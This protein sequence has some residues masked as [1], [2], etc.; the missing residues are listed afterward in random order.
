MKYKGKTVWITGAASGI[1]EALA[2]EYSKGGA[3]I[4]LSDIN[5]DKLKVVAAECESRGGKA[6][7]APF[8]LEDSKEIVEV[9]SEV[10]KEYPK[11]DYLYNNGGISQRSYAVE[12]PVAID[13]KIMETNFFGAVTLTKQLLPSLISNGGGHIVVTSSVVGKFGFP[14]RTAYSASKHALQGFFE[15]LRAELFDKNVKVTI[16]SPGKIQTNISVNAINKDGSRHGVMDVRQANG[17][18]ADICAR[19][20]IKAVNRNKKELWLA[21]REVLMVYIRLYLPALFHRLAPKVSPV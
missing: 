5:I 20:I 3:T 6:H 18:P 17:M 14:L 16:V 19:R 21:G 10:L 4:I 9:S 2:Y 15:A 1:G 12:T 11:I 8:N 13:R 7:L